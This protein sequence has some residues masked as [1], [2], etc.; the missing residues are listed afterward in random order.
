[1]VRS[2]S[3]SGGQSGKPGVQH[4]PNDTLNQ[5]GGVRQKN[6]F[7]E[8]SGFRLVWYQHCANWIEFVVN[9]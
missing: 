8:I 7:I 3:T 2:F 4:L 5:T 1:M 6:F 9:G